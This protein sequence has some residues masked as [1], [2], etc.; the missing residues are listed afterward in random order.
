M[1]TGE[2]RAR[3]WLRLDAVYCAG[4]GLL[5]LALVVPL[6]RF[7]DVPSPV[8]GAIGVGTIVWALLLLRFSQRTSWREPARLVAAANAAVSA[9]VA[10]LVALA[11]A[12]APRLL[13]AAVALEVGAFAVVQARVLRR[14]S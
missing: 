1:T 11:P 10:A 9:G 13:L 5:A 7:F 6:G 8:V 3:R 14:S 2:A 12:V 4:A